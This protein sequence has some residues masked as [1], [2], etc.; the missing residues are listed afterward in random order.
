MSHAVETM[1][2][3]GAVPWHGLGVEVNGD[4]LPQQMVEAAGIDWEVEKRPLF[5]K[6]ENTQ[7]EVPNKRALVRKTDSK[8]LDIVGVNWKPLQNKAAFEF[9][10]A[11]VGAGD[12]KMETAGSLQGGKVIWGL[13]RLGADFEVSP[14][15]KINGYLLLVSPHTAGKSIIGKVTSTRVVCANTLAIATRENA[16]FESRFSH[17]RQFDPVEAAETLG[18]ARDTILDFAKNA[19]MLRKCKM[20]EKEVI[21]LLAPIYCPASSVEAVK[22]VGLSAA[23]LSMKSVMECYYTA[24]GAEPGTAWGA[25]NAVTFHA[26]HRAGTTADGRLHSAWFGTEAARKQKVLDALLEIA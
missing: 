20:S 16:R 14:G 6:V 10:T 5:Y 15:D 9:F 3:S 22:E 19:K 26:D 4:L 25:L 11:F 21:D 12:A 2:W 18:I 13:A 23:G 8:L 1:A 17:S 7:V 24:P